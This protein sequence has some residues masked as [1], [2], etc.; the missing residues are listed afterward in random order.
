MIKHFANA[1]QQ[2]R[3]SAMSEPVVERVAPDSIT[4]PSK[5]EEPIKVKVETVSVEDIEAE[6]MND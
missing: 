2:Y 6:M 3:K 1:S 4:V 5:E